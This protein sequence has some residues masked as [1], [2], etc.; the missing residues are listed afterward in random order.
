M[1]KKTAKSH[2]EIIKANGL[3]PALYHVLDELNHTLIVKHRITGEIKFL[4]K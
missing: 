3:N 2:L 1:A 4:D